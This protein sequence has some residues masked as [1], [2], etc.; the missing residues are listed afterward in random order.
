MKEKKEKNLEQIISTA[1]EQT[2]KNY[3][4]P[5][6]QIDSKPTTEGFVNFDFLLFRENV[7]KNLMQSH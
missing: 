4:S 3:I 2:L 7:K 1:A 6:Y 5:Y